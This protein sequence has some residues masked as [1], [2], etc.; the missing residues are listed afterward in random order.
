MT[1]P[2]STPERLPLRAELARKALHAATAVLPISLA[3]GWTS[4]RTLQIAVAAAALLALVIE[5]LRNAWPTF[6]KA[7]STAVGG[8]LRRHEQ[9]ALT[10][11]TW[12]ALAMAVVLWLAPLNAAVAA[13]WAAAFGDAAA[14]V[15]G[16]SAASWRQRPAN[17]KTLLGSAAALVV[18]AAGVLWLTP[19]SV[20][21]AVL[22]G[23]VAAIAER[24]ARPLDDNLRIALVVALTATL[25]GLR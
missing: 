3:F 10:G 18:T 8:M 1:A 2:V 12:L 5:A 22:L 13:L 25:L 16:R 15:V 7:F 6:A 4:Q 14:A 17:G 9:A 20:S 24:P 11:A 21:A 19:A 23:V